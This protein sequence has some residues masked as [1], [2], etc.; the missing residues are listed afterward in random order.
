MSR[1][2]RRPR[3]K[4]PEEIEEIVGLGLGVFG[5]VVSGYRGA[6]CFGVLIIRI[7]LCGVLY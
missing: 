3:T 2:M 4:R 7:L 6:F 1:T 5:F